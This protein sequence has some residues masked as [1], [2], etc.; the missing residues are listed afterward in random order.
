MLNFLQAHTHSHTQNAKMR[1]GGTGAILAGILF[2]EVTFEQSLEGCERISSVRS[3]DDALG[4]ENSNGKYWDEGK[5]LA[6]SALCAWEAEGKW[7]RKGGM[8][9]G[10]P[11]GHSINY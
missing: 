4:K 8:V 3:G 10:G 2:Q 6:H 9:R 11:P 5:S 1:A 7:R